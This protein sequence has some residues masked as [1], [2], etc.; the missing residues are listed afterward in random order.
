M[1]GDLIARRWEAVGDRSEALDAMRGIAIA[2]VVARH[3]WPETF[4]G[5]GLGVNLFFVLSG[6]LIG[7]IL[8][9]NRGAGGYFKIFYGRRAFRILPL[10]WLLLAL[11]PGFG[12]SVWWF[13]AFGQ[14]AGWVIAAVF[15]VG[16]PLSV[17]WSLAVEEQFYLVLPACVAFLPRRRLVLVLW[18]CVVSAPLWRY[19]LSR[20]DN[21]G[22]L[23]LL[24]C[25]LDSLMGGTLIACYNRGYARSRPL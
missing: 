10:Y 4:P 12:L 23:L 5:G 22:A 13:L 14:N 18:S 11:Y 21:P 20:L 6:Y 3:Y 7:G 17:T 1:A 15:P 24:P 9:D 16:H 8:L 19:G 25:W 2:M